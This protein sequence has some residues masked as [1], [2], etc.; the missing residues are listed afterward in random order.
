LQA[1]PFDPNPDWSRFYSSGAEIEA[2]IIRT[3]KKWN[4]DRD[5]KL[6][7]EVKEARWLE[8]RGQWRLTVEHAGTESHVYA[9]VLLSGQ[10]VLV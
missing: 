2:Y 8:D 4:L 6:N 3:A 7:H 1:F 10:G 9:D 5:V